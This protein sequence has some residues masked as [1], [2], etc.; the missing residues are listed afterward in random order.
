MIPNA[1]TEVCI[2]LGNDPDSIKLI[3][4][5]IMRIRI[6][7]GVCLYVNDDTTPDVLRALVAA[8][9]TAAELL[10]AAEIVALN[11]PGLPHV[12]ASLHPVGPDYGAGAA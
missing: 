7:E 10:D 4:D 12:P 1:V 6:T 9:D 5:G 8:A 3:D 2:T 11:T